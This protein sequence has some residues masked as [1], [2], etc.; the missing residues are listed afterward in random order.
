MKLFI[1]IVYTLFFFTACE[2][3]FN[4]NSTTLNFH[5][6]NGSETTPLVNLKVKLDT[7]EFINEEFNY[8]ADGHN[9]RDFS[10]EVEKGTYHLKISSNTVEDERDS[11]VS[12]LLDEYYILIEYHDPSG[13]ENHIIYLRMEE[14]PIQFF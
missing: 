10:Y 12:L 2:E 8:I 7:I 6:L 4:D 11:T 14:E 9:W 1:L 3:K 13:R 5:I